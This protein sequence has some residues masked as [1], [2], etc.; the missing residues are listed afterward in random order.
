[1]KRIFIFVTFLVTGCEVLVIPGGKNNSWDGYKDWCPIKKV[2]N[3]YWPEVL[4]YGKGTHGYYSLP[5]E[6]GFI[7]LTSNDTIHGDIKFE[8]DGEGLLQVLPNG[9]KNKGDIITYKKNNFKFFCI[10]YQPLSDSSCYTDYISLHGKGH[11]PMFWRLLGAKGNIKIFDDYQF[12]YISDNKIK[13]NITKMILET[14]SERIQIRSWTS[15]RNIK[16]S[17]EHFIYK[18]YKQKYK[19]D[20]IR[21]LINFILE[22]ESERNN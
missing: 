8:A 5:P 16:N 9:E 3:N 6:K 20:N 4:F 12:D 10:Y 11:S 14:G 18:I 22:K 15:F 21:S 17:F 19:S 2:G 7:V 13:A 1:M